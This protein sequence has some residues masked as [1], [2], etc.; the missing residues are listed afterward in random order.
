MTAVADTS[1]A[2]YG[3][4]KFERSKWTATASSVALGRSR[5]KRN[6]HAFRMGMKLADTWPV[7]AI[8]L[9]RRCSL[10]QFPHWQ[11]ADLELGLCQ[12]A[13]AELLGV[14]P[15]TV[16]NWEKG[17]GEPA[18]R[19]MAGII[20]FLGY[21]PCTPFPTLSDR[22]RAVRRSQGWTVKEAARQL[23]VD[24]GTWGRWEKTGIPWKR[25]REMVEA[26]LK[27]LSGSDLSTRIP[28]EGD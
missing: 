26:F 25:H 4:R 14:T 11:I 28:G 15:F 10:S 22:M 18:I 3:Y 5:E 17:K 7:L 2:N 8:Q 6:A 24:A 21:D 19:S 13:L 20:E 1:R 9:D 23:G 27:A 12:K 16:L